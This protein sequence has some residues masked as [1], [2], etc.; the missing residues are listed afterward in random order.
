V[1]RG[2]LDHR[3]SDVAVCCDSDVC[4]CWVTGV[5]LQGALAAR[6]EREG[7]RERQGRVVHVVPNH[8]YQYW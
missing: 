4:C 3:P 6:G 7:E 1:Q 5:N 8:L 2:R